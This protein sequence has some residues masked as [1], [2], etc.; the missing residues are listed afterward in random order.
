MTNAVNSD[1]STLEVKRV[2]RVFLVDG[3]Y[4]DG[5]GRTQLSLTAYASK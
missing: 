5:A 2:Y 1:L 3:P 4:E